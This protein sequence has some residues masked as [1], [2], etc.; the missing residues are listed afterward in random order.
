MAYVFFNALNVDALIKYKLPQLRVSA[1]YN[2]FMVET[3]I[4]F[5]ENVSSASFSKLSVRITQ[6]ASMV[7]PFE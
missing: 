5:V 1:T 4:F 7:S 2:L 6:I 3:E